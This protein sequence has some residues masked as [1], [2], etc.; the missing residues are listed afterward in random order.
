M[1]TTET[2]NLD[3]NMAWEVVDWYRNAALLTRERD[4]ELE[5]MALS[6]LGRVYAKVKR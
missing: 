3:I 5:A 4:L 6:A 1:I 2:E